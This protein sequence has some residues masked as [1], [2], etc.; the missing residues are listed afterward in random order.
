MY[1]FYSHSSP[2]LKSKFI[3]LHDFVEDLSHHFFLFFIT[4]FLCLRLWFHCCPLLCLS[5]VFWLLSVVHLLWLR[6]F[7]SALFHHVQ[8]HS[9]RIPSLFY[10]VDLHHT[11]CFKIH[12]RRWQFLS[13]A[14]WLLLSDSLFWWW[15]LFF[16]QIWF[17]GCF[18]SLWSL[19]VFVES[20]PVFSFFFLPDAFFI[21]LLTSFNRCFSSLGVVLLSSMSLLISMSSFEITSLDS[22]IFSA[23]AASSVSSSFF[24]FSFISWP[25]C[26]T[27]EPASSSART[28]YSG[29]SSPGLSVPITFSVCFSFVPSRLCSTV[30]SPSWQVSSFEWRTSFS[31]PRRVRHVTR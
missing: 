9:C 28:Q 3:L 20:L 10:H 8:S 27:I 19:R 26:N 30:T 15:A 11:A 22:S 21:C 6:E 4:C 17:L 7:L 23:A 5:W 13:V 24:S 18:L 2:C 1:H 12:Q 31:R 25:T 16:L 14:W 29:S